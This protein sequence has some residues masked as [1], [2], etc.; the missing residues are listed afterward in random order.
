MTPPRSQVAA[1]SFDADDTLWDFGTASQLALA[2]V[3]DRLTEAGLHPPHGPA[4]ADW[5]AALRERVA[6]ERPGATLDE[7]RQAAFTAALAAC[8]RPDEPAAARELFTEYTR[9]RHGGVTPFPEV[10]AVLTALAARFPLAVT[11]NGNT[12]P[13][14]VA[15][16]A[17]RFHCVTSPAESGLYKPDPRMFHL[18]AERLGVLPAAVLHVG[19]HLDEDALG[20]REAGLQSRWLNRRGPG[21]GAERAARAGI[22]AIGSLAE[23]LALAG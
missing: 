2:V 20:A 13:E 9:V 17:G 7:L 23:L 10:V 14:L 22:A 19:D 15:G 4:T 12:D 3:A 5:L 8:G 1:I 18:T 16:L 6:V 11:T 21:P